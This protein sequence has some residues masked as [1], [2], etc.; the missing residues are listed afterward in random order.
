MNS[1]DNIVRG[2]WR[3]IAISVISAGIISLSINWLAEASL[4]N[5]Q[6][7][8]IRIN[9]NLI[10]TGF[11][12]VAE[13]AE[14]VAKRSPD[15]ETRD[16]WKGYAQDFNNIIPPN[17]ETCVDQFPKRTVVPFVEG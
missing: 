15:Q 8:K 6:I 13:I 5:E 9:C 4:F 2:R 14:G 7:E 10:Q 1:E 3:I 12:N 16:I 17:S 11:K